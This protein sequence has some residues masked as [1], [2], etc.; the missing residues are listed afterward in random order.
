MTLKYLDPWRPLPYGR[1][2][3]E[4]A[5]RSQGKSSIGGLDVRNA[6]WMP[7]DGRPRMPSLHLPPFP[8]ISCLFGTARS[9]QGSVS[10]RSEPLTARTVPKSLSARERGRGSQGASPGRGSGA[11]PRAPYRARRLRAASKTAFLGSPALLSSSPCRSR[12]GSKPFRSSLPYLLVPGSSPPAATLPYA[13]S[14]DPSW[15]RCQ[16]GSF[17]QAGCC[18]L[19]S[20]LPFPAPR[21]KYRSAATTQS[22][23]IGIENPRTNPYA[24]AV[25]TRLFR[26]G[27]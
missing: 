22:P 14:L 26:S 2:F 18:P 4:K 9:C 11:A 24:A 20:D 12:S 1:G 16:L 17:F 7:T 15:A 21:R 27:S 25:A 6:R 10:E 23:E 5:A 13:L 19:S 8:R 3:H